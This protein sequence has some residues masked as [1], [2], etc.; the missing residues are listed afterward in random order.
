VMLR[1]AELLQGE[2]N[3]EKPYSEEAQTR[4]PDSLPL[5]SLRFWLSGRG[6]NFYS[7]YNGCINVQFFCFFLFFFF[8]TNST[9][10]NC[11]TEKQE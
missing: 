11:S 1:F 4:F 2:M 8:F 10:F 7:P 5:L 3:G 9:R 6:L